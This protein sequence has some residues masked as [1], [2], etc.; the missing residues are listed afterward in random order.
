MHV[1]VSGS[2][3]KVKAQAAK[4]FIRNAL[5][6]G[7]LFIMWVVPEHR[8]HVHVSTARPFKLHMNVKMYCI[9]YINNCSFMYK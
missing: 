5:F 9:R 4:R 8:L 1:T 2:N 6:E 7:W 3:S